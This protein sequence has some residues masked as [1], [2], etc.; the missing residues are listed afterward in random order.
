MSFDPRATTSSTPSIS[1]SATALADNP[2][3]KGWSIINMGVNPL[4]FHFGAGC[5]VSPVKYDQVLLGGTVNDDGTGGSFSDVV[6]TGIVT[7][8]GTSPRYIA[9]ERY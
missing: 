8:A 9:T 5:T 6:Y 1:S 4:Y 2:A 7:V 3:R